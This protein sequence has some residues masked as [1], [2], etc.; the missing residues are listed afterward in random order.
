MN[1]EKKPKKLTQTDAVLYLLLEAALHTG[2]YKSYGHF[3]TKEVRVGGLG[4]KFVSHKGYIRLCEL[5]LYELADLDVIQMKERKAV[6][7]AI[8]KTFLIKLDY[9][10]ILKLMG[11]RYAIIVREFLIQNRLTDVLQKLSYEK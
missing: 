7:G 3:V 10:S 6:D 5:N 8:Y 9:D 2:E 4:T 1:N 11:T